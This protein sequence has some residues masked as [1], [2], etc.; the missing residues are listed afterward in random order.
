MGISNDGS[1]C[2][3][4]LGH[5]WGHSVSILKK[6]AAS[7]FAYWVIS[8]ATHLGLGV[9]GVLNDNPG[10]AFAFW[11]TDGVT[12]LGPGVLGS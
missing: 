1:E 12:D 7:A 10:N 11:F 3:C 6:S 4:I 5:R 9:L 2:I 8:G